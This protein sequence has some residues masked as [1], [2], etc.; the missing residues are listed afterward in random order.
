MIPVAQPVLG[1]AEELALRKCVKEGWISYR[2]PQVGE[3]EKS[4]AE[5]IG[6]SHSIATSS[7]TSAL[8]LAL[9]ALGVKPGDKVI[10][11]ALTFV[12]TANAVRYCGA[13]PVFVDSNVDCWCLDPK[14]AYK[15]VQDEKGIVGIIA[16]HLYGHPADMDAINFIARDAG[17]WVVEDCAESLGALYLG[18]PTGSFSEVSCFSFFANKVITTGEGGMCLTNDESLAKK[19]RMLGDHGTSP[20]NHYWHEVVGYNYRM[21][22]LQAAVGLAQL[23]KIEYLLML[24]DKVEGFYNTNLRGVIGIQLPPS[25]GWAR[26][27]NWQYTMLLTNGITRNT[28]AMYLKER[29]IETRPAFYTIPSMPP[30]SSHELFP[31]AEYISKRGLSLPSS[32]LLTTPELGYI[33]DCIKEALQ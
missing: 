28:L 14:E 18:R 10:V 12:A 26:T 32:P 24:R 3:F 8:H 17:I 16:V 1:E 6:V 2:G 29:G 25:I 5:Y 9:L 7:G 20:G 27:V 19:I 11:P 22:N 33:C 13:E 15:K 21:T 4:F 23:N 30:Y 31:N